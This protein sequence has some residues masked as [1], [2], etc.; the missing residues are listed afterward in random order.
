MRVIMLGEDPP[1]RQ[2]M[3]VLCDRA[4]WRIEDQRI[5]PSGQ[6]AASGWV[7]Q[8]FAEAHREVTSAK[9]P[10]L[11]LLVCIDGDNVGFETRRRALLEQV[12]SHPSDPVAIVCPTWSIE[13]WL[14]FFDG[15]PCNEITSMK[16]R[17]GR[18]FRQMSYRH[19]GPGAPRERPPPKLRRES[20]QHLTDGFLDPKRRHDDLPALDRSR[21]QWD[22]LC[23]RAR[24]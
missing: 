10:G 13:T 8:Q 14:Q 6:G 1:H 20:L 15:E 24:T 23:A 12:N 17:S 16:Q 4:G 2:F 3:E 22:G 18:H 11:G 19:V 7:L 9:L 21:A 5:Q